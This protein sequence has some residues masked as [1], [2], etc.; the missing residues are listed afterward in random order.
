MIPLVLGCK[1]VVLVGD[2]QQLGPV[3]MNKKAAKAG[4]ISPCSSVLLSLGCAPI[5][6]NVQY[7]MHPCLSEFPSNMFYEG[8][9][10]NGVTMQQRLRRDV[11]FPWPVA[12]SPYDVLV[13]SW[14]T[15]RSPPLEPR[16]STA[17]KQ[18]MSRRSSLASSKQVCSH[19]TSVS[20]LL[21]RDNEATWSAPCRPLVHSRRRHYKEIEV[22]SVDAFPRPREGLHRSFLCALQRSSRHWFL[23]RPSPSQCCSDSSQ[24]WSGHPWEPEGLVQASSV[25]L[26]APA[27]QGDELSGG[28]TAVQPTD[29]TVTIQS[30]KAVVP[31][32][33]TLSDVIS[34]RF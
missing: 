1:Q 21:M 32:P 26:S 6:L 14:A 9:L 20:S 12:D 24:V 27:L 31:W 18:P 34:A 2:H 8:S 7:R 13:Q 19:K 28:R 33:T 23:E 15:K 5:R 16:T 10:Q 4:L 17:P 30:P 29:F 11:D 25:A 22:A 3:I